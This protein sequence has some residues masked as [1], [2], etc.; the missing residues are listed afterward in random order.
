MLL[1]DSPISRK[2]K[3]MRLYMAFYKRLCVSLKET[4]LR[5]DALSHDLVKQHYLMG[6]SPFAGDFMTD[7]EETPV[8][9]EYQSYYKGRVHLIDSGQRFDPA[10]FTY[11]LTFLSFGKKLEYIDDAFNETAFRGWLEIEKA[12]GSL[13]LLPSDVSSIRQVI[14]SIL[15]D[16]NASCSGQDMVQGE[17]R[18]G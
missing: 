6:S 1:S 5:F 9:F 15:P 14:K 13:V 17:L 11:L 10:L 7:F 4:I 16:P 8:Y 2:K 12:L 18:K 3:P